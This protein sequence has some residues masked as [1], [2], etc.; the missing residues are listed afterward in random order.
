MNRNL[1]DY[2]NATE[3]ECREDLEET[4]N[5][6]DIDNDY[7]TLYRRAIRIQNIAERLKELKEVQ[8]EN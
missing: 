2:D 1:Y 6:L 5:M 8:N 7:E 3:E 4:I